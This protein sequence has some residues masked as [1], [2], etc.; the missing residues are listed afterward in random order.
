MRLHTLRDLHERAAQFASSVALVADSQGQLSTQTHDL[1]SL[2]SEVRFSVCVWVCLCVSIFVL[3]I[4]VCVCVCFNHKDGGIIQG[5]SSDSASKFCKSRIKVQI[6][7]DIK[8][9]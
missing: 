5:E 1:R 9:Q 6:N 8:F 3:C 7:Q 2:L 4:C